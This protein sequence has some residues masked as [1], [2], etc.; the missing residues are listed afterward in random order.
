MESFSETTAPPP[1]LFQLETKGCVLVVDDEPAVRR[2]SMR[3][4]QSAGYTVVEAADGNCAIETLRTRE[5][6]AVL[7]DITMPGMSGVQLLRNIR[8]IDPDL[9]VVL[10]T[11][12]PAMETAVEAVELGAL[13]YMIKPVAPRELTEMMAQ[14][15][16]TGRV[17]KFKRKMVASV[18]RTTTLMVDRSTMERALDGALSTLW[19]A[20]QPIVNLKKRKVMANEALMRTTAR[21]FPH[22]GAFLGVAEKLDRI[23]DVGR[24]IR[25]RIASDLVSHPPQGLVF[26]NLHPA[27]LL[28]EELYAVD[29]PLAPFARSI[30]LEITE[31]E[32]LADKGDVVEHAKALRALGYRIA[33]DDLGAGYSGLNHFA[34][35]KP[36]VAKIDM[37]LVRD[38][39][40]DEVKQKLVTSLVTLCGDLGTSVVAEGVETA[41]ERDK[42]AA[43]GCNYLQGYLFAKPGKPYP[44]VAW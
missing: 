7:S 27:D 34:A 40:T 33:I 15:V 14:A 3:V 26:V 37:Q 32:A 11:A 35:L 21:D 2:A 6:D 23:Q 8:D 5:F 20:Y 38:I 1:P 39:D 12:N 29:A 18:G 4:L 44:A 28:D 17:A 10:L 25:C 30:V 19:M 36:E 16:K 43:L 24:A 31:R 13:K 9:P 42:L 41:E 22:P